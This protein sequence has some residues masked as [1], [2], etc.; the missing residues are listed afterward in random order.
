[1]GVN[2]FQSNAFQQTVVCAFQEF[3]ATGGGSGGEDYVPVKHWKYQPH[4]DTVWRHIA[5]MSLGRL[6]G[7]LGGPARAQ[8]LTPKQLSKAASHA[9]NVR[10]KQ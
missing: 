4:D 7:L 3:I 6:G 9:A 5:A 2:A 8:S 1:M 10:W